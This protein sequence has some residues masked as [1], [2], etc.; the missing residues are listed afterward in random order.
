MVTVLCCPESSKTRQQQEDFRGFG[1]V[2]VN[3]NYFNIFK[4]LLFLLFKD[5]VA[6]V[7][8]AMMQH[9]QYLFPL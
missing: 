6:S 5:I 3:A 9:N 1:K 8:D 4:E 7:S 2:R